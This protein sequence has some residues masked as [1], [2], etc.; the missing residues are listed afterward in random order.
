MDISQIEDIVY[1]LNE[2][3]IAFNKDYYELGFF[4]GLD[5][6]CNGYNTIIYYLDIPIWYSDEDERDW[7]EENNDYE[8]LDGYLRKKINTINGY[9]SQ[10]TL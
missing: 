6:R 5:L 3:I 10:I 1:E 2:E 4:L 7:I 9:I 8:P